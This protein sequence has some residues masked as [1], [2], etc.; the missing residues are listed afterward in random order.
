ME[1]QNRQRD[2]GRDDQGA[3]P[4]A[5]KRENHESGQ[6][7]GNQ[8]FPDHSADRATNKDRLIR[9][10]RHLQLRWNGRLDLRQKCLDARDH[11]QRGRVPRL[12][13][14]QQH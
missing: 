10:R 14:R 8:S 7:C 3:S 4:A 5:E 1:R 2:R 11:V 9:Q 6:A 13:D 12:L